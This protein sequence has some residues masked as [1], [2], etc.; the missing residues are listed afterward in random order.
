MWE[1][2][3]LGV[4]SQF[5]EDRDD[6]AVPGRLVRVRLAAYLT[7]ASREGHDV[8]VLRIAVLRDAE[9][10][11]V[12]TTVHDPVV[13]VLVLHCVTIRRLP[14]RLPD[15]PYAHPWSVGPDEQAGQLGPQ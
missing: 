13:V 11:V 7:R 9:G 12:R 3:G 14:P 1:R 8:A 6:G 4:V 5:D 10:F 15:R 2:A